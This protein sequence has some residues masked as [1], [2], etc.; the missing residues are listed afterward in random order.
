[1]ETEG[2]PLSTP[3]RLHLKLENQQKTGSFKERGALNRLL[4]LSEE[5]RRRGVVAASAGNHGLA[6]AFHGAKLGIPV[7]VVMPEAA[8][9]VKVSNTRGYGARVVLSGR[10]LDESAE[11][12]AEIAEAEGLL[13]VPPFDDPHV[14]AGQGT[15][16]L[17][18]LEVVPSPRWVV[19]PVGGGGLIGGMAVALEELAPGARVIGVEAEAAPSAHTALAQGG[20]VTVQP[21]DTL[22]DGIAIK[23]VGQLTYPLL[24]DYV[25][26]L[27]LVSEDE[28]ASAILLLLER[29]R[30]VVEGAGA[31]GL[32]A[33]MAGRIEGIRDGDDVVV[34]L[35]GGNI[36]VTR[37]DR[38]IGHGLAVDGRLARLEVQG[39]DR[40][41]F[42][43]RIAATVARLGGN[44]MEVDHQRD[45]SDIAVGSVGIVVVVES[46]GQAHADRIARA[47]AEEGLKVT[48]IEAK[49]Q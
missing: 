8:P 6:L 36:D 31:V 30:T 35:S 44:I 39:P 34:V 24:R 3:G 17:E 7:T 49:P 43:A 42:L 9:L 46:E 45:S 5:E 23:R 16:A 15:V 2:L 47:L 29:A 48:P 37:I 33:L 28:I 21:V 12:A 11:R 10:I 27:V 4:T 18:I 14:I 25:D 38:I 41:G 19:V 1:M 22:A 26:E 13:I 20:V 40:P 32:A